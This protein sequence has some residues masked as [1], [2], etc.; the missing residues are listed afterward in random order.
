MCELGLTL[1]SPL[2][3]DE[4]DEVHRVGLVYNADKLILH[5]PTGA[6]RHEF[7]YYINQYKRV[8]LE[9]LYNKYNDD[10]CNPGPKKT[11]V[12]IRAR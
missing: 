5:V 10:F 8:R 12:K 9:S 2:T 7:N 3:P 1:K 6:K 4:I 11:I